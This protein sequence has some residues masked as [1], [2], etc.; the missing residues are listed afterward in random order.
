MVQ[1]LRKQHKTNFGFYACIFK[2]AI[3]ASVFDFFF[4]IF[5][6]ERSVA[7]ELMNGTQ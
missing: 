6:L 7:F 3:Y 4:Q 2:K 1:P 5:Q